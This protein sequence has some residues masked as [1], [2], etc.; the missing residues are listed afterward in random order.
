LFRYVKTVD[1]VMQDPRQWIDGW[2]AINPNI[3]ETEQDKVT[4]HIS[5][6]SNAITSICLSFRFHSIF[7]IN[8]P[9]ALIFCTCVGHYHGSQGTETEYHRSTSRCSWSDFNPRSRTVF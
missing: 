9:L 5:R 1:D 7:W 4:D 2:V 8:W 3:S 6:G